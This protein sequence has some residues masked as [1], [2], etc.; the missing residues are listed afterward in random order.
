MKKNATTEK[1][2]K[3]YERLAGRVAKLGLVL[4]GTITERTIIREDPQDEGKEKIYGP[5][6]QWTFKKD[7]KTTTVNLTASQ[8]K[9]YRKA[10]ENHRTL[11]EITQQMRELSLQILEATTEGVE[12]RKPRT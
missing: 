6:Y 12:R 1:M 5:Y 2:K 8:A 4:Q 7:G 10:I 11:E 9:A 3:G